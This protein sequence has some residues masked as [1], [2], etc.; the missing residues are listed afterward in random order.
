MQVTVLGSGNAFAPGRAWS[1]MLVNGTILLDASP[2]VLLNLKRAGIDPGV[3]EVIF[4][5]HV[6]GDHLFGLPFLMLEYAYQ[7]H[8]A[9][10][11]TIVGPPGIA[12]HVRSLI[13]LAY[14]TLWAHPN[15]RPLVW[16]EAIP[17]HVQHAGG[18]PFRAVEMSHGGPNLQAFGYQLHLSDGI[19]AYSG[20]TR[21]DS[22]VLTLVEGADIVVVEADSQPTSPVHLGRAELCQI[23][24]QLAP[25]THVVL[26]HLDTPD[27]APWRDLPVIVANDL[28][29]YEWTRCGDTQRLEY[30][31]CL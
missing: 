31:Q 5:S 11:L 2:T 4:I 17:G 18:V 6:H 20:D 26:T 19:L 22:S 3:L 9:S 12:Q 23:L 16:V 30:T 10:P 14:P 7:T 25:W 15:R 27:D 24:E 1:S 29:R 21:L 8:G 28:D 13:D